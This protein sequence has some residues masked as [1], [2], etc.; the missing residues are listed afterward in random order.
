MYKKQCEDSGRPFAVF[1][2]YPE[3]WDG[4][5]TD[6]CLEEQPCQVPCGDTGCTVS[7]FV[8]HV[9]DGKR[10]IEYFIVGPSNACADQIRALSFAANNTVEYG[11]KCL[12]RLGAMHCGNIAPYGHGS[13][14]SAYVEL[15]SDYNTDYGSEYGASESSSST[16]LSLASS[17]GK[18]HCIVK[19][20]WC[21]K[22]RQSRFLVTFKPGF[23]GIVIE[24]PDDF[25]IE[26][27]PVHL[28]RSDGAS[29]RCNRAC[30]LDLPV[31]KCGNSHC[32]SKSSSG[33]PDL[34]AELARHQAHT[35]P[36]PVVFVPRIGAESPLQLGAGVRLLNEDA[37]ASVHTC[38]RPSTTQSLRAPRDNSNGAE[39]R[40]W[41]HALEE[42]ALALA[43]CP[44]GPSP[45]SSDAYDLD[46]GRV[47]VGACDVVRCS[48][49]LHHASRLTGG[50]APATSA[51]F[52]ARARAL[53][54]AARD[55][56]AGERFNEARQAACCAELLFESLLEHYECPTEHCNA[57]HVYPANAL[58]EGGDRRRSQRTGQHGS[59]RQH[60]PLLTLAAFEECDV[61][62]ADFVADNDGQDAVFAVYA[63]S[64]V[65]ALTHRWFASVLH[66]ETR[67]IG[68]TSDFALELRFADAHVPTGAR[69]RVLHHGSGAAEECYTANSH[70]TQTHE[71][72]STDA[73]R[74][75][76]STRAALPHHPASSA[77]FVN[78]LAES[79][80]AEPAHIASVYIEVPSDA[81]SAEPALRLALELRDRTTDCVVRTEHRGAGFGVLAPAPYYW[82]LEGVPAYLNATALDDDGLCIGGDRARAHCTER[83]ECAGGYCE[84]RDHQCF[85][86]PLPGLN[87]DA[88]CSRR[89][90]CPYGRCYGRYEAR[91][92]EQGAYPLLA[93]HLRS[94]APA[95]AHW[96]ATRTGPVDA[97][98]YYDPDAHRT[99]SD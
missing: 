24:V 28:L 59:V 32:D 78:T 12:A 16:A 58:F 85:D 9:G 49:A 97:T 26:V 66:V 5:C 7:A 93:A 98:L 10:V 27:E 61:P 94:P 56:Y 6:Q 19:E 80:L 48:A 31:P 17:S 34:C 8:R 90:Q 82:P 54:N 65:G 36:K 89:S 43:H 11:R 18:E 37:G 95:N 86:A 50:S 68:S 84:L 99:R 29:Y 69:V 76:R 75:V 33:E 81:A 77:P 73:I 57:E 21:T 42:Q 22:K 46:L 41:M 13:A 47:N 53:A 2:P 30:T 20:D 45:T 74:L 60:E 51:Q 25:V 35:T 96:F 23:R 63:T 39:A 3:N 83:D 44:R 67:A 72:P 1:T 71:C 88:L 52:V 40:L 87:R 4:E 14:L 62:S 91:V 70:G 92:S 64:M 15:S 55:L 38:P 79:P